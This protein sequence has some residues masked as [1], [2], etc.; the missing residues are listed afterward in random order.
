MSSALWW[1]ENGAL[2]IEKVT[3][4]GVRGLDLVM[5]YILGGQTLNIKNKSHE[6]YWLFSWL[7]LDLIS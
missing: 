6:R 3:Y 7:S 4:C 5:M 2:E 1:C